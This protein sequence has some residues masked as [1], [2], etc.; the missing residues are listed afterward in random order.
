M[1]SAGTFSLVPIIVKV[2]VPST[3]IQILYYIIVAYCIWIWEKIT[4]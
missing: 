4:K 1:T 2:R 3:S